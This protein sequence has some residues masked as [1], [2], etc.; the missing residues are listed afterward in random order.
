MKVL[1]IMSACLLVAVLAGCTT[2][3]YLKSGVNRVCNA[4]PAERALLRLK[5]DQATAPHKLR[6][7]C[8]DEEIFNVQE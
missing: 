4:E 5:V 3:Q 2:T 7:E 1:R 8:A 6:L